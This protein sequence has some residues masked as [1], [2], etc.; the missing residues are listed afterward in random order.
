MKRNI[1]C[2]GWSHWKPAEISVQWRARY[3]NIVSELFITGGNGPS[4]AFLFA[5]TVHLY[6]AETNTQ[7]TL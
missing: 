3:H 4:H 7:Q 6:N 5:V 1:E 2:I